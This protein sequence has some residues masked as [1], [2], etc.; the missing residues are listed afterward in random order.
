VCAEPTIGYDINYFDG[1]AIEKLT[2]VDFSSWSLIA[3][4][5]DALSEE[6]LNQ[7]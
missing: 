3:M 2:K 5:R 6:V 4:P 7:L 1:D